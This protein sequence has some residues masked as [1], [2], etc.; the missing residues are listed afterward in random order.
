M[1]YHSA[2]KEQ[3]TDTSNNM[4]EPQKPYGKWQKPDTTEDILW[5][6]FYEISRKGKT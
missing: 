6:Y 1:Q 3:I 5:F 4:D 2:E